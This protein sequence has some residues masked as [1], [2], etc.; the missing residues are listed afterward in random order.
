MGRVF[1]VRVVRMLPDKSLLK[2]QVIWAACQSAALF[3]VGC[4][5][6]ARLSEFE[7]LHSLPRFFSWGSLLKGR[8]PASR[9]PWCVLRG[10]ARWTEG[11]PKVW[12]ATGEAPADL[13][14]Q[15]QKS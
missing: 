10:D 1:S 9:R 2:F 4:R 11:A 7:R 6:S 12:Y 15:Q 8:A 3:V 5:L 14:R 13:S